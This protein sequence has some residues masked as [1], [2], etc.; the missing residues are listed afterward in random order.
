MFVTA[1]RWIAD[2]IATSNV[3]N[4]NASHM[5]SGD[6]ME[7]LPVPKRIIISSTGIGSRLVLWVYICWNESGTCRTAIIW[8]KLGR[9][10][11]VV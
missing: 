6:D 7:I 9:H 10:A 11:Q 8:I 5:L 4:Q 3:I 2:L 1:R